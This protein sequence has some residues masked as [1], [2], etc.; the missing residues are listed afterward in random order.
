LNQV[1]ALTRDRKGE[2]DP[3]GQGGNE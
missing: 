1:T 3:T 2:D